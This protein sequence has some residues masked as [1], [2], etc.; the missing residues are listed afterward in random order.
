MVKCTVTISL[1]IRHRE[2][3][4]TFA[5]VNMV[6]GSKPSRLATALIAQMVEQ[7]ICNRQ[8]LGSKPSEGTKFNN[9]KVL[10]CLKF[11]Y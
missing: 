11:L 6:G 5:N 7:A 2:A 1:V 9:K 10:L 3:V 4:N 8:V